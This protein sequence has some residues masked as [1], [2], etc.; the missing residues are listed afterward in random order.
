MALDKQQWAVFIC[1]YLSY[2][3]LVYTRKS[4][5]YAS[6]VI[7]KEENLEKNQLGLILSSQMIGYSM[8]QFFGG[9]LVDSLN[10]TMMLSASLFLTGITAFIFT[11]F[12]SVSMFSFLW[13]LNGLSQGPGWPSCALILKR[14][15]PADQFGTWWSTLSSSINLA[16]TVGPITTTSLLALLGWRKIFSL[17]GCISM[18]ISVY[19][20]INLSDKPKSKSTEHTDE[21]IEKDKTKITKDNKMY[22]LFELMKQPVFV[23][24]CL[25]Y[26]LI[27]LI[28]GTCTYWGQLYLIQ[29]KEQSVFLGSVFTSSQEA[30]GLIGALSAGYVSDY[31]LS[32]G[33]RKYN[34]RLRVALWCICLPVVS[35]YLLLY[36]VT[37]LSHGIII[38]V[39]G[40]GIGFGVSGAIA[41][42]GVTAMESAPEGLEATAHSIAAFSANVG[43]VLSGYPLS[44]IANAYGWHAAFKLVLFITVFPVFIVYFCQRSVVKEKKST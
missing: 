8:S 23:G 13:F 1:L 24:V 44:L 4:F 12:D 39:V 27:N 31:L 21:R 15:F 17:T 10:P 35:I 36:F 42:F 7:M 30:G 41:L 22:K 33:K 16:G 2:F 34:P 26:L 6:P 40:G 43:M 3:I 18:G 20:L 28:R 14:W 9:V 19:I 5:S 11:M 38:S 37:T 32:K 25:S 29:D